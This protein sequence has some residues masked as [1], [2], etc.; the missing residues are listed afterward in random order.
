MDS[1]TIVWEE[2]EDQIRAVTAETCLPLRHKVLWPHKPMDFSRVEGDEKADHY[3]YYHKGILVGCLGLFPQDPSTERLRKF[4]VDTTFQGQ[5]YGSHL[6]AVALK[7]AFDKPIYKVMA[8]ARMD[9]LPFY[10]NRGFQVVG[11]PFKKEEMLYSAIEILK[12]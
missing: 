3:G 1:M 12:A 7:R 6:L 10:K 8:Y 5:G 9:A 2:G 11:Q 4:C